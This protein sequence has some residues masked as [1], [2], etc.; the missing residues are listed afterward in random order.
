MQVAQ[1]ALAASRLTCGERIVGIALLA[2]GVF[3]MLCA[4]SQLMYIYSV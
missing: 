2:K 1:T 3:F 4:G